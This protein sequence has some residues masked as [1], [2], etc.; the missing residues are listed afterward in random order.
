[1]DSDTVL[2][3]ADSVLHAGIDPDRWS[4][5]LDALSG[6]TEGSAFSLFAQDARARENL[7]HVLAGY[8][9]E[10]KRD[11][12]G[13][14]GALNPFAVTGMGAT[15]GEVTPAEK[16]VSHSQLRRTEFYDGFFRRYGDLGPGGGTVLARDGQRLAV[17]SA[18]CPFRKE[19]SLLPSLLAVLKAMAPHVRRALDMNC[20]LA[21]AAVFGGVQFSP[22][23]VALLDR[24]AHVLALSPSAETLFTAPGPPE[25]RRNGE[26]A[27]GDS[28][29]ERWM[30]KTLRRY[31]TAGF[32]GG[33]DVIRL[34]G[35]GPFAAFL[36]PIPMRL[37]HGIAVVS[38]LVGHAVGRQPA[39][40][41]TLA[42]RLDGCLADGDESVPASADD[43]F[44]RAAQ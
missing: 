42:A 43:P 5:A 12:S 14:Y 31:A 8:P 25:L 32:P 18:H 22:R 1:M 26:L 20:R 35:P 10:A 40:I 23:V 27:L 39:G 41:L 33:P 29:A 44:P 21:T 15:V 4:V 24:D 17:L 36:D 30:A 19:D 3:L 16:W 2:R 13:R 11:F 34:P 37:G 6:V 9:D 7:G 38:A 28:A